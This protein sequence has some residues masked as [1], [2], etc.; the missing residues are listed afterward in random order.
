M[1]PELAHHLAFRVIRAVGASP[2][3]RLV[4]SRTSAPASGRARVMG[5]EFPGRFGL[6]AGFDKDALSPRGLS[7]VG[8]GFVAAG[9]VWARPP[10]GEGTPRLWREGLA[11]SR[12]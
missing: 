1:D 12:V 8:F 3:R 5:I 10:T 6:A 2:L 11:R 9:A 4:A 7:L